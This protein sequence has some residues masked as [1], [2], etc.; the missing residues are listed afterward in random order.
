MNEKNLGI[1]LLLVFAF[2]GL[3][4]A[5]MLPI[6]ERLKYGIDLAGGHSL[7]YAIDTSGMERGQTRNLAQDVM[8]VLRDRVDP[9]GVRNLVSDL[10]SGVRESGK[11][12]A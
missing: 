8:K 2:V 9:D 10:A 6:N 7:L 1:K 4:L 11:K 12:V 3:M 5:A